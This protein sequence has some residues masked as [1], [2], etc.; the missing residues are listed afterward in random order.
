MNKNIKRRVSMV[1][2]AAI[3]FGSAVSY[4]AGA[5]SSAGHSGVESVRYIPRKHPKEVTVKI[6]TDHEG[7]G[8][9]EEKVTYKMF[10]GHDFGEMLDY[11]G[12]QD[13]YLNQ[14]NTDKYE[15]TG[16]KINGREKLYSTEQL[17]ATIAQKNMQS[18]YGDDAGEAIYILPQFAKKK[19]PVLDLR[20][21]VKVKIILDDAVTYVNVTPGKSLGTVFS[22]LNANDLFDVMKRPENKVLLGWEYTDRN[23]EKRFASDSEVND[24]LVNK[25]LIGKKGEK[26]E[27]LVLKSVFYNLNT[28]Q[29]EVS[30][31]PQYILK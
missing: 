26:G 30:D 3:V 9:A 28:E 23:G 16:W 15:L 31:N 8:V 25:S 27:R 13:S 24:V 29:E 7:D 12:T 18:R 22:E 14:L 1:I 21:P 10:A 11:L 20:K 2:A 19:K 5:M 6:V 4:S 17:K